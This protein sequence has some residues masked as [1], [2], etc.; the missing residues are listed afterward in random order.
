LADFNELQ[1]L[2]SYRV[3]TDVYQEW[4]RQNATPNPLYDYYVRGTPA[5]QFPADLVEYVV[6]SAIRQAAPLNLRDNPARMLQPTGKQVRRMVMMR[7]FNQI[8]LGM[9]ALQMLREPDNWWLQQKGMT[10]VNQQL[11]DLATKQAITKQLVLGKLMTAGTVYVDA[12]GNIQET[13]TNALWSLSAGIPAANTGQLARANFFPGG[14]GNIIATKWSDP[15]ALIL[16][17]LDEL[18]DAAQRQRTPPL[19][20][21]W[22]FRPNKK[23]LRNNLQIQKLFNFQVGPERLDNALKDDNF[24]INNY[25]FHFMG[26]TYQ[27]AAGPPDNPYI[28]VNMAI[29][30]PELGP[31]FLNGEGM[32]YVPRTVGVN[33]ETMQEAMDNLDE[34]YGDFA[35]LELAHNPVRVNVFAGSNFLYGL[36]APNVV[37]TPTVDF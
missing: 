32:E 2:L 3:L 37:F 10:E 13:S 35:Y 15:N 25:V 5:R 30:T 12:N 4:G 20:H 17:Q 11:E 29:I 8:Q 34:R 28:P 31:W 1:E 9:G 33:G 7:M 6:V 24:E 26:A 18:S 14:T 36:K 21:V 19:R 16:D 22:L 27:P 23:W